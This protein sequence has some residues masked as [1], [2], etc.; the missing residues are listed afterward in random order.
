MT[1][2]ERIKQS[3]RGFMQGRNGIDPLGRTM[4]WSGLGLYLVA[5]ISG[6]AV[7]SILSM[8]IYVW[9]IFRMFS[10]NIQKRAEENRRFVQF[11]RKHITNIKQARVRHQNRK[12]YTYF[13][14]PKCKAWLRLPRGAGNAKVTCGRCKNNFSYRA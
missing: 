3:L 8:A 2:L 9:A 4:V 6:L 12:Q 5:L 11:Q 13:K 10:R 1:F 14:C 7:L